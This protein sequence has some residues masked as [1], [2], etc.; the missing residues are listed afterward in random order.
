MS[1]IGCRHSRV[2]T[3]GGRLG[4]SGMRGRSRSAR[5]AIEDHQIDGEGKPVFNRMVKMKDSREGC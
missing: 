5:D 1:L 4:C 2:G 3:R